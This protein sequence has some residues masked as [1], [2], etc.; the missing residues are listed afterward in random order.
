MKQE[1]S[2]SLFMPLL[3]VCLCSSVPVAAGRVLFN[4]LGPG[5][6]YD[7]CS[8]YPVDGSDTPGG[9]SW[10][11]AN[12]FTVDGSGSRSVFEINLAVGLITESG[13]NRTHTFYASIWTDNAGTPGAQVAGAY[14]SLS[15][16]AGYG[17]CC[18]LVS[19]AGI[20]GVD[21]TGGDQY[22]MILGPLSLSDDTLD[23]WAWNNQ[24]VTGDEQYST[25][26]GATWTDQG[27]G[28]ILGAF[29][30]L[31]APEPGS[32]LLLGT[33]LIGM[34]GFARRRKSQRA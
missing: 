25:N 13:T 15:T 18:N 19:V 33:G 28:N 8:G 5:G 34:L 32:L 4:D 2:L 20:T 31:G 22:F 24:L 10:T 1:R 29:E 27:G 14:W 23:G 7:C 9:E 26:G 30:I 11:T 6:S 17:S 16:N 3:A 21:L 12:L